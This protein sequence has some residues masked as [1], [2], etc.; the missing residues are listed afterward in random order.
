[1]DKARKIAHRL[2]FGKPAAIRRRMVA[3]C[4]ANRGCWSNF[5]RDIERNERIVVDM[6][7]PQRLLRQPNSP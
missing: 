5:G 6:H 1:M 3:D 4:R 2:A 7:P